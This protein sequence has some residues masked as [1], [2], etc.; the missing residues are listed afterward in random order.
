MN[1]SISGFAFIN[2]YVSILK[3][4]SID[5]IQEMVKDWSWNPR[6]TAMY[7]CRPLQRLL[8]MA[9]SAW[10]S[11][12]HFR[13]L[14]AVLQAPPRQEQQVQRWGD[15]HPIRQCPHSEVVAGVLH[16]SI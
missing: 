12:R 13:G 1:K 11:L 6:A 15:C 4:S 14:L 2:M 3:S 5:T 9:S 8:H 16:V 7:P 10:P